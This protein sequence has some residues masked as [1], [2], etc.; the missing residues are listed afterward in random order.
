MQGILMKGWYKKEFKTVELWRHGKS[1]KRPGKILKNI[2]QIS[3][4]KR[5]CGETEK[6]KTG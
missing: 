5:T 1:D 4:S 6:R 2:Q 3:I